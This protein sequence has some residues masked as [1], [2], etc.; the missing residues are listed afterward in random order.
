MC[1]SEPPPALDRERSVAYVTGPAL[2]AWLEAQRLPTDE[3]VVAH[4]MRSRF[5]WHCTVHN[6]R[7]SRAYHTGVSLTSDFLITR[8]FLSVWYNLEPLY[9]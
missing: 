7:Q 9:S 8:N 1:I 2:A 3:G 5:P 4:A 6:L